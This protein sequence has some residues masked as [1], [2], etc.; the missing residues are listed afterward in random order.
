[1]T[2]VVTGGRGFLG[3]NVVRRLLEAGHEVHPVG[4]KDYD[5]TE[6]H[7][8]RALYAELRPRVVVHCAA[9][10]GGIGANVDNPGRFLYE[11]A[12]MGLM[13]LE[14][15][16]LAGMDKLVMISTSCAYPQDA[17]LPL[18]EEDLWEG[19][20]TGATG[21][22]GIAKRM[23]HDACLN[24]AKQYGTNST[25]LM[26][27]NL[28]GPEDNFGAGSHVIPAIIRRYID[29]ERL[30]APSV[31]NWGSGHATREF[32]HV[33]DAARAVALAVVTTTGPEPINIGTGQAV[34]IREIADAV[35]T[36]VG[37]RGEVRWD[38]TKPDGQP[39]RYFDTTRAT[40]R[41]AFTSTV[42][43]EKGLVQTVRWFRERGQYLV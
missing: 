21:P 31:T 11:N 8:V 41:L 17:P 33:D 9:A 32:L 28:Y 15:G 19:P 1:M 13:L 7:G 20:P 27:A 39:A 35:K 38:T 43:L 30:G 3:R 14:E 2:I 5:L 16:R 24:Y 29:A 12:L 26:L 4:S 6:Q 42:P 18:R 37:Y 23:L 22:Y 36:A 34:A 40:Q 10:V 25:V